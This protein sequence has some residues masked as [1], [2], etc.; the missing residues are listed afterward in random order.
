MTEESETRTPQRPGKVD[1]TSE[2]RPRRVLEDWEMLQSRE[3]PPL[4]VPWWFVVIVT[5]MLLSSVILTLPIMGQRS[6]YERPWFDWGLLVGVGYGLVFLVI[7][8]FFMRGRKRAP[9]KSELETKKKR[10]EIRS[11]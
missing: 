10:S 3:E 5:G 6:G 8:Y 7:I 9:N 4:K 11:H 2:D 1:L